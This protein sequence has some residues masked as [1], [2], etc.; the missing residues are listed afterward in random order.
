TEA[1]PEVS[2]TEMQRLQNEVVRAIRHDPDVNGVISIVGVSSLNLTPN[3]GRLS[4]S[5]KPRNNRRAFVTEIVDRLAEAV[6]PIPG[7]TIYF[8]PVQDIQI[9]TRISRSQYQYT[10]VSTDA[11]EVA[12]W[13]D[14]LVARLGHSAILRDIASEAQEG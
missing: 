4:I 14:R 8:L 9:S 6:A 2:F 13:S 1:G 3:S 5:L 12:T 10:L 11:Q 7:V